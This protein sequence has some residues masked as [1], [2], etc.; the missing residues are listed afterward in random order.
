MAPESISCPIRYW[1]IVAPDRIAIESGDSSV[2]YRELDERVGAAEHFVASRELDSGGRLG[3]VSTASTDAISLVWACIRRGVVVAPLSDRF[4]ADLRQEVAGSLQLDAVLDRIDEIGLNLYGNASTRGSRTREIITLPLDRPAS[5]ILTS[6]SSG[7]PKGVLHTLGNHWH[8]AVGSAEQLSV[9]DETR[10]LLSLPF[11]H[12]GGFAIVVRC[13]LAG[14]R[15]VLSDGDSAAAIIPSKGVTHISL[16]ATQLRR[17]LQEENHRFG[18]LKVVLVGGGPVPQSL[19]QA[20]V[21]ADLPLFVTYGSTEACSLVTMTRTSSGVVDSSGSVL[22]HRRII[23]S[24]TGEIQVGGK[25]LGAGYIIDGACRDF[26]T[27]EGLFRTGDLGEFDDR[28]ELS[29]LGRADNMFVSGGENIYPEQIERALASSSLVAAALVVPVP[30]VE[31]GQRPFAFIETDGT[32]I[33]E[34]TI[35]K[36]RDTVARTLPRFMVPDVFES[37]NYAGAKSLKIDRGYWR[38]IALEI[39]R[40]GQRLGDGTASKGSK[41]I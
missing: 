37:W 5:I 19:R 7:S 3:I 25:T 15:L 22:P 18:T 6:G 30:S 39:V 40:K 34:P 12:I 21:D 17:L 35:N 9:S 41:P 10:W 8:S 16:V 28:G 32:S 24:D 26:R 29:I 14:A 38:E 4:P 20:A 1:S 11:Y 36:L 31:F 33:D 27:N 13:L 23:L 2:S